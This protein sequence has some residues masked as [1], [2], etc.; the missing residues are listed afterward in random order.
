M[1]LFNK[2]RPTPTIRRFD[3]RWFPGSARQ[4]SPLHVDRHRGTRGARCA[5]IAPTIV[6]GLWMGIVVLIVGTVVIAFGL[7]GRNAAEELLLGRMLRTE[8]EPGIEIQS[9][10]YRGKPRA[11]A[12][13]SRRLRRTLAS[14]WFR[15]RS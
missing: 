2:P 3:G 7:G 1:P 10:A 9:G 13:C 5:A 4:R 12:R 14:Q 6:N 11:S 8:L 15:T